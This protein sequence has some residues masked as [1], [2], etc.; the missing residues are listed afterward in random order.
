MPWASRGSKPI[1]RISAPTREYEWNDYLEGMNTYLGDD[2]IKSRFW[3]LAQDA[4]MPTL[5]EYETRKG[6][7]FHS[8]AVG[9]TQDQTL[10][11]TAGAADKSFNEV[12]RLAQIFTAGASARLSKLE[13]NLKNDAAATGTVIVALY[14]D[15]AGSPGTELAR[16]SIAAS[17]LGSSYDYLTA[18][19]MS[20]PSLT[21]GTSYWIVVYVQST[22]TG[23]YKWSSTTS[24]TTAKTSTDSGGSW[25]ATTYSLNFREHYATS[26]STIGLFRASKSDGT[27]RTLIGH[28][29]SLSS[30]NDVSGALTSIKTGLSGSSTYIRGVVVNDIFY[31]VNGFDGFRK[32]DF[33]TE[34]QVNA[35]NYS[36]IAEHKGLL[37]LVDKNDPNKLVFSNF[38]AYETFTS[39]DFIYVPSPKTGDPITAI[40][41]V[42]GALAIWTRKKK[43]ILYGVDNA[44]FQLDEAPSTG[45]KGTFSPE[46]VASDGNRAYFL[47]DDG[48]YSFDGTSD[49]PISENVYEDVKNMPN[50][51]SAVVNYNQGRVRLFYAPSGSANNSKCY[52]WNRNFSSNTQDLVESQ[53]TETYVSR[54]V[55]CP[56]DSFALLVGSSVIGQAYWQELESN[57]YSNLGGDLS[58]E[59]KTHYN[60]F[61]S[62]AREKEVRDW[63]PRFATQDDNYTVTIQY[64]YDLRNN[65]QTLLSP[66]V[67][68]AGYV[69]GD[70]GT[71]WGS[72]TWGTTPETQ[73]YLCVPG[74]WRRIAFRYIH[75]AT[76]QPQRFLGHTLVV[77]TKDIK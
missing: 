21:S 44:T 18:R 24:A 61:G 74:M 59:L 14:T 2:V 17:A 12:T 48:M 23:S 19:F 71:V 54:A 65:F 58:F 50:K 64:A 57:D 72:F 3:R 76:R 34:S 40:A 1:P 16:S 46:T 8:A 30:V 39:T 45:R 35:T 70:A 69:W 29:T 20:A 63:L 49:T 43:Y 73:S 66:D 13:V 42:N 7:D 51:A 37:F 28:G 26:G 38:A 62:A 32:W 27:K 9:E 41:P 60:N 53:D 56:D 33:T 75:T 36:M 11:S 67:Q 77:E 6:C 47:S 25:S 5:G 4:R 55:T 52:V 10:T 31:Y 68:G 22:G 15:A